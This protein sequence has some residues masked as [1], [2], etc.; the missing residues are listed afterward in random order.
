MTT[1]AED[2]LLVQVDRILRGEGF[3][4]AEGLRRLLLYLA[5]RSAA[6][7]ADGLK[8]YIVGVDGLGKPSSYDPRSDAAVRIQ[9][10]R[11][12]Q[13]LTEYYATQGRQDPVRI[14]VPKGQFRVVAVPNLALDTELTP[15]PLQVPLT[16]NRWLA[17]ALAVSL[18]A[19]IY[20]WSSLL[21]TPR[22]NPALWTKELSLLWQPFV[23]SERPLMIMV[24]DP[25]FIQFK[26]FGAYRSQVINTWDEVETSPSVSII[27]KALKEPALEPS[28]RYT[29]VSDTNASFALAKMLAP[30]LAN[31]TLGRSSEFSWPL[32]ANNNA[33]YVGAERVIVNQLRN[34]PVKFA[35]SYD[36]LGIATLDRQDGEPELYADPPAVNARDASEDGEAFAL[37]S[38][39][40]GPAGQSEL[41]TFT[42]NSAPARLAAVQW[43][44]TPAGAGEV[45][46]RLKAGGRTLP[47]YFQMILKIRF[48][49]GT[50]VETSYVRHREL[51]AT[52][53]SGK[54]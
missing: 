25:L 40:P 24:A 26:G 3:R 1:P 32:L 10:G 35:Y 54:K 47:D 34:F 46:S 29:S 14:E 31:L 37:I 15:P 45:V 23:E 16:W 18:I 49:A 39:F 9:V 43:F 20:A 6:G 8:E 7:E 2:A 4:N 30:R 44:T 11:L 27:R 19:G 51:R 22:P 38:R 42:S 50:P 41:L 5:Q 33:V 13:K 48:R 53:P 21:A 36:Y 17:L 28:M 12:R 52:V